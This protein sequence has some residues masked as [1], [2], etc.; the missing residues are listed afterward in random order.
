MM[1]FAQLQK[2]L[3]TIAAF[4]ADC[5][6]DSSKKLSVLTWLSSP[7]SNTREAHFGGSGC[8]HCRPVVADAVDCTNVHILTAWIAKRDC[9]DYIAKKKRN[10]KGS[11]AHA[12]VIHVRS[13]R[14]C[15]LNRNFQVFPFIARNSLLGVAPKCRFS[16]NCLRT[17]G[18]SSRL[19]Q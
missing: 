2:Y 3:D 13:F 17:I 4:T 15:C 7:M 5:S 18:F 16:I 11:A 6:L 10:Q 19:P 1:T 8:D 12:A 9:S 14:L